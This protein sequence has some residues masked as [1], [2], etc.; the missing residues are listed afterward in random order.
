MI[1]DFIS[2]AYT[3]LLWTF[4]VAFI[5]AGCSSTQN[6]MLPQPTDDP[7]VVAQIGQ[8][9]LDLAEFETRY[10]RSVGGRDVALQDSMSEY[11]DFLERYIDFRLKVMY[12]EDLN[13]DKDTSLVNEIE[14]YRGQLAR[15]YLLEREVLD[16]ILRDLYEKKQNMVDASHILVRLGR[17]ASPEEEAAAL[18]KIT[19]IRDSVMN[20]EDFG[21]LAYRN[22]ED[23]SARGNRIGARGRLGY[24]IGGM[25]VKAFE[26][27]AY[28]TPIDSVS[29]VFRS[30]FGYHIL[31]VHDRKTRTPD[32]WGS[33]IAIRHFQTSLSDTA[34]SEDRI[35]AIYERLQAG[36][37]FAELAIAESEDR[38]TGPR[39]G[40]LG[41][42]AFTAQGLPPEFRE[43]LFA[44]E[45]PGDYSEIV[46]TGYGFHIIKLDQ[47][48][49]LQS[50]EESYD[51]LKNQVARLPRVKQA[52]ERM[53]LSIR[54]KY[55]VSVDT[56]QVLQILDGRLFNAANILETPADQMAT[57]VVSLGDS[58]FKFGDIVDYAE[59]HSTPF[60]PDTLAMVNRT[61][62]MFLN[63]EAMNYE[64]ARLES[65]DPEFRRILEEFRDGLLLFKLMEDSVW[66][67]AANDTAALKAYHAERADQ[68]QFPDRTRIIGFRHRSDSLM[69][70]LHGRLGSGTPLTSLIKEIL[71]DSTMAVRIDTTFLAEANNS[72]F[73]RALKLE[74]GAFSEPILNNGSYL[75]MVN[76]GIDKA[77]QKTFEEARSE[78]LNAYQEIL[79]E[80]LIE[81][82]RAKYGVLSYPERLR[83]AFAEDKMKA[84]EAPDLYD[85]GMNTSG[86]N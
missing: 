45:N 17:A 7:M 2:R 42:I 54:E 63:D 84:K 49:T 12:A 47:R 21:D 38:E 81:R 73:D 24:F 19:A 1:K 41:R 15:P 66:T 3:P 64:A 30:D 62:E 52:E 79:E 86:S 74:Q 59:I 39:G 72:I 75:I 22:S 37:D 27:Q 4:A 25:M 29:E 71:M 68:Y 61:I 40:Q 9:N 33:H 8:N 55:G 77:R 60:T 10:A 48:E 31:Y 18:N 5:I 6:S 70:A 69:K 82:L 83:P 20:G 76:D 53:A 11:A 58:T 50:F 13:L 36:E 67:A 57:H 32:V 51:D 23:P 14:T 85:N 78:V 16:P 56:A 34:S 65:R 43:A 28:S 35:K 80:N 44:L 26:D 46:R